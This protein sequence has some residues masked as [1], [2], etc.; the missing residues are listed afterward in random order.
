MTYS[1]RQARENFVP[2]DYEEFKRQ[3]SQEA[4]RQQT[5]TMLASAT[6]ED[7]VALVTFY[8]AELKAMKQQLAGATFA[9]ETNRDTIKGMQRG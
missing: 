3:M 7:L 4:N 8:E 1:Y 9:A 5:E 6:R 2:I